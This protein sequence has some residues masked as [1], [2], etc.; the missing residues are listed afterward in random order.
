MTGVVKKVSGTIRR[1]EYGLLGA[2]LDTTGELLGAVLDRPGSLAG[3][4]PGKI[5][6]QIPK[7]C[8]VY[9]GEYEVTPAV[10][11]QTLSTAGKLLQNNVKINEIPFAEVS[12]TSGGTT[13]TIGKEV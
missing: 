13:V 4:I 7:D 9:E 10:Q 5:V 3:T 6:F 11:A 12:N 8:P 1:I 2:V